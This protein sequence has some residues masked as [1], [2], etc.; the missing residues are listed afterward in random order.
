MAFSPGVEEALQ[1]TASLLMGLT[2]S[3]DAPILVESLSGPII[4]QLPRGPVDELVI[5]SP[6]LDRQAGAIG[7]LVG[8]FKPARWE[9]ILDDDAVFDGP[10]VA[11]ATERLNGVISCIESSR[12]HHG[13]LIEWE[14][15]G[16]RFAL[17]GS[18]NASASGLCRS[19]ENGGNCELGLVTEIPG[20][21]RPPTGEAPAIDAIRSTVYRQL[22]HTESGP[23]LLGATLEPDGLRLQLVKPL[24]TPGTLQVADRDIWLTS[25]ELPVDEASIAVEVGVP[26]GTLVRIRL[27]PERFSNVVAA[28]NLSLTQRRPLQATGRSRTDPDAMFQDPKAAE[29]FAR[30]LLD[31]RAHISEA[32]TPG[33]QLKRSPAA[34]THQRFET[35][36][37]YLDHLSAHLGEAAV[38]Y[39][40]ALPNLGSLNHEW[41]DPEYDPEDPEDAE[42]EGD[43]AP[44]RVPDFQDLPAGEKR[45]FRSWARRLV[46]G[47]LGLLPSAQLIAARLILR[48]IAARLWDDHDEPNALLI[49]TAKTLASTDPLFPEETDRLAAMTAFCLSVARRD[50]NLH[51]TGEMELRYH[52]AAE[53]ARQLLG[54]TDETLVQ[55]YTAEFIDQLGE[56]AQP[57][58]VLDVAAHLTHPLGEVALDLTDLGHGAK[59]ED[60]GIR[61]TTWEPHPLDVALAATARASRLRQLRVTYTDDKSA[62]H[63]GWV[64]NALAI[65]EHEGASVNGRLLRLPGLTEPSDLRQMDPYQLRRL[66][67]ARWTSIHERPDQATG[68][69][70]A[71][72]S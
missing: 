5:C 62:C 55:A 21:L 12:Y 39:G 24:E 32:R 33:T 13:K 68:L 53:T 51:A 40:L 61:I 72:G 38:R 71:S 28:T 50:L 42:R 30:D 35:W 48:S 60:G 17:T 36:E 23:V 34:T 9:L 2:P 4:D 14:R 47:M 31:L 43:H 15:A 65:E 7:D 63:L 64:G 52:A 22:T 1:R 45:R 58:R 37:E 6:F 67:A 41:V 44:G 3:S 11:E 29:A 25:A 26:A 56:S 10:S 8:R 70:G 18:A 54:H 66:V 49:D 19:M 20:S 57:S 46:E 59:H 69:L 16:S 27:G